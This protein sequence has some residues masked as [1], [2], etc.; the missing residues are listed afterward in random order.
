MLPLCSM[1]QEE[2]SVV[3]G[4][5]MPD[6]VDGS[7]A[8]RAARLPAYYNLWDA[9]KT[10]HQLVILVSF[11]DTNFSLDNPME[12]YDKLFNEPGF[13]EEKRNAK[14][15]LA[16]YFRD[17]SAGMFNLKFDVY[18]PVLVD[19]LAQPYA[20]PT[21]HRLCR[22]RCLRQLRLGVRLCQIR[23]EQQRYHQSGHLCLCRYSWQC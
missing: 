14:G 13:N 8:H 9:D 23:L 6:L 1:A 5:C 10:Y 17:Q 4:H 3:R 11:R 21:V 20:K 22:C 16:D 12:Y 19:T 18:G 7:G 15:C 2:F